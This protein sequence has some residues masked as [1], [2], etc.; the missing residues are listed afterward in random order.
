MSK[1]K[2]PGDL[3]SHRWFGANDLRPFGHRARLRQGGY[4]KAF[5]N[6]IDPEDGVIGRQLVD[7]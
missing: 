3:R 2:S 6:S 5:F 1:R 7:S 4:A